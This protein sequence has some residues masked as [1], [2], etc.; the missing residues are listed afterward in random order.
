MTGND[1]FS[2]ISRRDL[3]AASAG[4]ASAMLLPASESMAE[5]SDSPEFRIVDT[6]ISLFQWPFRRLPL[7]TSPALA[8]KLHSLG[9]REA[10]AASFEGVLQRDLAGV[11]SRLVEECRKHRMFVPIGSVNPTLPGWED[12]L[13]SCLE[14][15]NMIGIRLHPGCQAGRFVQI[16]VALEDTRTQPEQLQVPDIDLSPLVTILKHR[17]QA[18]VQLLN[19]KPRPPLLNQLADIP[20]VYFDTARVEGTDGVPRLVE[21]VKE[22]RVLFGSHAP[23]LIPEAALIRTHESGLLDQPALRAVLSESAEHILKGNAK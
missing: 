17:P 6:N 21:V 20:G 9:V 1:E 7:D 23:C 13:R 19:Y 22:G 12:D 14:E 11:N 8:E 18:R 5:D 15:Y 4:L 3:L 16:A 2:T 10:W